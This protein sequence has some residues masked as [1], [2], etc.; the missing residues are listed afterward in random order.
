MKEAI[1]KHGVVITRVL[2][3][4]EKMREFEKKVGKYL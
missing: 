1:L 4:L 3:I 2:T